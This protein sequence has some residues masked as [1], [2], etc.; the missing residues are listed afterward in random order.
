[1]L[2]CLY[3]DYLLRE[4]CGHTVGYMVSHRIMKVPKIFDCTPAANRLGRSR[5]FCKSLSGPF[6][7]VCVY[8][9]ECAC[10][11]KYDYPGVHECT[12]GAGD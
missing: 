9:T 10:F 7:C 1:M 11:A 5:Q 12:M 3:G 2:R 8:E 4:V 6:V